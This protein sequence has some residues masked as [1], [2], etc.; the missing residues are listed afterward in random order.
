MFICISINRTTVVCCY[1]I[2]VNSNH[3]A[4][5]S[6]CW[7]L[8]RFLCK[9]L[10]LFS[11]NL[12]NNWIDGSNCNIKAEMRII[13]APFFPVTW[14]RTCLPKPIKKKTNIIVHLTRI[15]FEARALAIYPET[16]SGV[17]AHSISLLRA[18]WKPTKEKNNNMG[19]SIF[20]TEYNRTMALV[21]AWKWH[22]PL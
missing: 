19:N 12:K 18:S 22:G 13:L 15:I 8:Q 3:N 20:S 2:S 21:W 17:A 14:H 1:G 7:L 9:S 6:S 16:S 11:A 4:E 10:L 5:H